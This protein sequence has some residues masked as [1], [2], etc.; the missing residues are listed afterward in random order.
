MKVLFTKA[1]FCLWSCLP[2]SVISVKAGIQKTPQSK[3]P[4]LYVSNWKHPLLALCSRLC[5]DDGG[6]GSHHLLCVLIFGGTVMRHF[7]RGGMIGGL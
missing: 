7:L 3:K 6:D 4:A 1:S 2:L 5:E